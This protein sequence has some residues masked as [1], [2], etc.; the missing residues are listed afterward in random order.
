MAKSQLRSGREPEK[1]KKEKVT[2]APLS[3][4]TL[5]QTLETHSNHG[6]SNKR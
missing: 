5:W 3:A 1:P 4:S 2:G 6:S